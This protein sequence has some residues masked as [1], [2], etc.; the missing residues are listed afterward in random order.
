MITSGLVED[1]KDKKK[2]GWYYGK[3]YVRYMFSA[4]G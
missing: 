2:T 1:G 4:T 3:I